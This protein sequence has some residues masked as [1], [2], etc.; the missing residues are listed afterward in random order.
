MSSNTQNTQRGSGGRGGRGGRGRGDGKKRKY[1]KWKE[2]PVKKKPFERCPFKVG[3]D[4]WF[5]WKNARYENNVF[6]S[7]HELD[8]GVI[9]RTFKTSNNS[10]QTN[11][12]KMLHLQNKMIDNN[13]MLKNDHDCEYFEHH[14]YPDKKVEVHSYMASNGQEL[15]FPLM[16]KKDD[17]EGIACSIRYRYRN[18]SIEPN[19]FT[20]HCDTRTGKRHNKY[21]RYL[22]IRTERR[23][24]FDAERNAI[25][26][27]NA[28]N[29]KL[30]NNAMSKV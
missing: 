22:K 28:L 15:S 5:V 10:P 11:D 27:A 8:Y 12:N 16:D 21:L 7:T 23:D 2:E 13:W 25:A 6:Y 3:S 4:E 9:P 30:T 14:L 18:T 19:E 26:M 1:K 20:N 29:K 17:P 24:E